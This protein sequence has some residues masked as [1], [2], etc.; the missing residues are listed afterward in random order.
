MLRVRRLK[1]GQ[2]N[3]GA[4]RALTALLSAISIL[5]QDAR[6]DVYLTLHFRERE[7]CPLRLL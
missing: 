4:T 6:A 7:G 1:L 5:D 2:S 3:I